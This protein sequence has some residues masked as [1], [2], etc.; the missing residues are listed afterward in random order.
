MSTLANRVRRSFY[1]DSVALMRIARELSALEGVQAASLMIGT[2]SNQAL[3]A[4]SGLLAAEGRTA[5]PDDLVIA[6]RASGAA[7]AARALEAAER[8][9]TGGESA[10]AATGVPVA[11]R[12]E[13]GI[14]LLPDAN[15]ALIS[16]PGEYAA[17]EARRALERGL[18]VMMFSD[19][20]PVEEEVALKQLAVSKGLLM[21]G[22]DCGT[23][24][25]GGAPLAF[26]N[27]VPVGDI[28]LVSASGTGLQE[29]MCLLAR[30]G[31]GVS[32]AIGVGGRDLSE[33]VG[34]L[35]TLAAFEMLDADPKTKTIVL[36]SKPPSPQVAAKVFARVARSRKR[37]VLC[38]LGTGKGDLPRSAAVAGTLLDAALAALG[39]RGTRKPPSARSRKGWLRGLF[40][41]GTLCAEAQ[42]ILQAQGLALQSNAAVPGA[43]ESGKVHAAAHTLID[44]GDDD[45][46]R[47]RPHPMIDPEIRNELLVTSLRDASVGVVLLDV[48]IGHGAHPDPAGLIAAALAKVP[49]RKALVLASVTGTEADPQVY[50]RQVE[51][52]R[53]AGVVVARSNAEAALAAARA[54]ADH[55]TPAL[56]RSSSGSR[57]ARAGTA[58]RSAG[59]RRRRDGP[60]GRS[61][62][63][64]RGKR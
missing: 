23:C 59:T 58:P 41:G 11:R 10:R 21:M 48:V 26:A 45:Y 50:S 40:C 37:V 57:S 12:F 30:S 32:Q 28:G 22:P 53:E 16:V 19:N 38:L 42:L 2:P 62:A 60:A 1:A 33:A 13:G 56:R 14:D 36:I 20:V 4:E 31:G 52:L 24:H 9:L 7:Q 25:I 51:K 44:L 55:S 43:T 6:V 18:H 29:V 47:G 64:R 5:K 63:S 49:G 34:G 8:L 46:T 17:A 61:G 27:A 3:L 54:L 15:L 35:M 39:K